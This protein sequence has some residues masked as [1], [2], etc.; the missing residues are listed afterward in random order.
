MTT[1]ASCWTTSTSHRPEPGS[2]FSANHCPE[3]ES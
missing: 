3:E 2:S 1:A